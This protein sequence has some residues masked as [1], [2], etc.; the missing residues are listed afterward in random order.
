MSIEDQPTEQIPREPATTPMSSPLDIGQ[1]RRSD[2]AAIS[3]AE[4]DPTDVLRLD[5]MFEDPE[6]RAVPAPAPAREPA[7][8][9]TGAPPAD[10]RVAERRIADR[11][12]ADRRIGAVP[13]AAAKPPAGPSAVTRLRRDAGSAAR[14]GARHTRDWFLH[15]DNTLILVSTLVAI[16][17]LLVVAL[18]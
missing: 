10:R 12:V 9:A 16:A 2:D 18:S 14:G 15:G 17:L 1:H 5:D 4:A 11:R 7:Y 8:A 3:G 6:R 13:V